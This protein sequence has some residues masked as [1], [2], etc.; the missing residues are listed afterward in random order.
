M[1]LR[2]AKWYKT[3]I[4]PAS[5]PITARPHESLDFEADLARRFLLPDIR[6]RG[7]VKPG[8]LAVLLLV[9]RDRATG[10]AVLQNISKLQ[11]IMKDGAFHRSD[12]ESVSV[13][14]LVS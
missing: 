5:E 2:A 8:Y 9:D 7:E 3:G 13:D 6:Y 14:A 12:V 10:V 4:A 11:V 1:R